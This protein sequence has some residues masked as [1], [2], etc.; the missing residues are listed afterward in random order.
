MAKNCGQTETPTT[1]N[2]SDCDQFIDSGCIVLDR[3]S[4]LIKGVRGMDGNTYLTLLENKI[5]LLEIENR[6]IR[7]IIIT[8]PETGIGVFE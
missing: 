7:Q 5:R 6:N 4:D 3:Q 2:S 8:T 1:D